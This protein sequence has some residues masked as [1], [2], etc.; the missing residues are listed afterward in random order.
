MGRL[1]ARLQSAPEISFAIRMTR[2]ASPAARATGMRTAGPNHK[3]AAF[4]ARES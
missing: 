1:T 2:R 4:R 3:I